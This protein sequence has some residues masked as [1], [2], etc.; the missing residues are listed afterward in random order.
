[1]IS[2][3]RVPEGPERFLGQVISHVKSSIE[4]ARYEEA[5]SGRSPSIKVILLDSVPNRKF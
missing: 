3:S 5:F 2:G 1:M 4:S